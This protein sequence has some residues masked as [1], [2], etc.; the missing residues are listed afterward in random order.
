MR[1]RVLWGTDIFYSMYD[2]PELVHDAISLITDTYINCMDK[3]YNLFPA[4]D[5]MNP[6]WEAF[7]Y[8]GKIVLRSDS[9]MN[10]SPDLYREFS[11]PYD[12]K[13]LE[14][15]NG[16]AVHFCGRG[17]H[18]IDILCAE[19]GVTAINMSQPEYNDMEKIYTNTVDKGIKILSMP[20]EQ[21]VADTSR[22][23][24]GH[25]HTHSS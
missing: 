12:R 6:H 19:K 10:V 7:F 18:Y 23:F 16:G 21:A 3:W 14:Y 20:R 17:D 11:L 15:F 8:R 25:V 1:R 13:L 22:G 24:H 2:E 4:D 9:A 5:E